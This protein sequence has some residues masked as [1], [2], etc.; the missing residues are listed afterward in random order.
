MP[1]INT[2][3][4]QHDHTASAFIIHWNPEDKNTE[5]K[6]L[7]HMH[8]KF[9]K[10]LQPGGHIEL[11]ETPW[12]AIKHE[13]VEE[14]GYEINQ[15]EIL[16]PSLIADL[17]NTGMVS[18]PVPFVYNTHPVDKEETHYHSDVSFLFLTHELPVGVPGEGETTDLRWLTLSE[19]RENKENN[20][21]SGVQAIS[22]LAFKIMSNENWYSYPSA[23][24]K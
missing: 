11:N 2:Q 23:H 24:F 15:L 14:T 3:N 7:V 6:L 17:S 16:Q 1:H 20:I 18:H 5:P 4:G 9:G 19:I 13:L 8:K 12:A 10:L 21:G 22:E